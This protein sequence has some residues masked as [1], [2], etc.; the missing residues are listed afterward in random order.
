VTQELQTLRDELKGLFDDRKMNVREEQRRA[1][2]AIQELN[3]RIAISL[4]G[5]GKSSVEGLRW[6]LA[7]RAALAIGVAAST[8]PAATCW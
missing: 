1:D 5:D 2:I 6:F 3:R 8:S 4:L 7:R